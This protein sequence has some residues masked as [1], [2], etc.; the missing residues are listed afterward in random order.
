[1]EK[2]NVFH[3]WIYTDMN[4]VQTGMAEV[5]VQEA[6]TSGMLCDDPVSLLIAVFIYSA[7]DPWFSWSAWCPVAETW[8]EYII[9]T[10]SSV[11]FSISLQSNL[12]CKHKGYM[13]IS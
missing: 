9:E 7:D 2:D 3:T 4:V 6:W 5:L 10:R 1:M 12:K 8:R 11:P 13:E